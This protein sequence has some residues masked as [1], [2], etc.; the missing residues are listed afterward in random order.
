MIGFGIWRI[1]NNEDLVVSDNIITAIE[2]YEKNYPGTAIKDVR[3]VGAFHGS[4][5]QF[6]I[7]R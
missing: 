6:K 1:D 5:C 7:E 2:I 4:L 3:F